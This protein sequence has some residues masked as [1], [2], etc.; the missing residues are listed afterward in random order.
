MAKLIQFKGWYFKGKEG[1]ITV[2]A[3]YFT[4]LET[5]T[6]NGKSF[7]C[8]R[9]FNSSETTHAPSIYT[10]LSILEIMKLV[11]N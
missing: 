11:N 6:E 1:L 7:T 8:I 3:D 4:T 10:E 2:N 5:E 9:I